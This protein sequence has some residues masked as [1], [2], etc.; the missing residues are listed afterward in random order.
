MTLLKSER[1]SKDTSAHSRPEIVDADILAVVQTLSQ[2]VDTHVYVF[3]HGQIEYGS[4]G[5]R[6]EHQKMSAQ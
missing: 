2:R 4:P 5:E 1:T 3:P 6:A